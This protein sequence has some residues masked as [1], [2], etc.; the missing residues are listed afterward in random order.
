[1][2]HLCMNIIMKPLKEC[3]KS[4]MYM[5]DP[6]GDLCRVRTIYGA[7]MSDLPEMLVLACVS[8]GCSPISMARLH[9][10]GDYPAHPLRHGAHTLQQIAELQMR[11]DVTDLKALKVTC[12]E[13]GLNGVL[14]PFW[15][16]WKFADPCQFLAPDALH[17]WH[18][19]FMDHVVKWGRMLLGDVELDR[20]LS[21]LQ[22]RVGF[23]HFSSGITRFKQHT[24]REQRDLQ[25]VFVAIMAGSPLVNT[26]ILRAFRA[27]LDFVY[28][29]QYERHTDQSIEL[30]HTVLTNFHANKKALSR[31]GCRDG[32]KRKGNFY[33]PKMELMHH[34]GYFTKL[35]GVSAQFTSDVTERCHIVFAK[36]PYAFGT[37][38]KNY[39]PQ[40]CRFIDRLER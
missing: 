37:N 40:M 30:L 32:K 38:K 27:Y 1:L 39:P 17:Q 33:I 28:L 10:F 22:P 26:Q 24:G 34:V 18:K 8:Q 2:F 21:V 7:H 31:A 20:R 11:C 6:I 36:V 16:D 9:K 4:P 23:C 5:V 35:L 29:G 14:D 15:E 3:S 25:R 19:M 13:M 12:S